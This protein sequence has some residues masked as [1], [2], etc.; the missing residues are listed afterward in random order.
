MKTVK[1]LLQGKTKALCTVSPGTP[2]FEA[3]RVVHVGID[4]ILDRAID[5][6]RVLIHTVLNLKHPLIHTMYP[7]PCNSARKPC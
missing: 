1:Q 5:R 2:V 3:R 4:Q 7:A 6:S